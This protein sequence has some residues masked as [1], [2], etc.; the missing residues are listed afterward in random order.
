MRK[1]AAAILEIM[2][3][4][5][6]IDAHPHTRYALKKFI[7]DTCLAAGITIVDR[8]ER[9][10]FARR[11]L[12]AGEPRP[13]IRDR[14]MIRFGIEKTMAYDAIGRALKLSGKSVKYRK[15]EAQNSITGST[16]S[17]QD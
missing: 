15:N 13:V 14:L 12:E 3:E 2:A 1:Q 6:R 8:K 4:V 9:V 10:Q 11:L 17:T 5:E 16:N 7:N